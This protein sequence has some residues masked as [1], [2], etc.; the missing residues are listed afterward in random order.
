MQVGTVTSFSTA[1]GFGWIT[2]ADGGPDVFLHHTAIL[3]PRS[4]GFRIVREGAMVAFEARPGERF[5]EA[6][7]VRA[8]A[9]SP[10]PAAKA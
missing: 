8:L 3:G 2:P 6:T 5:P 10:R 4:E 7:A 1:R 9:D